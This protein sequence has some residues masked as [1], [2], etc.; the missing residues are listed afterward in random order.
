MT[1]KPPV[2]E[3]PPATR[4]APISRS[5]ASHDRTLVRVG[6]RTLELSNLEKVLYPGPEGGGFT[7]RQV[8]DYYQR[9]AKTIVPHLKDR[10]VT[11]KRYPNGVDHPFFYEKRCPSYKP[12]WLTTATLWSS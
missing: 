11:L 9:I 5:H 1:P 8:I 3:P 6:A 7:K 4:R 12:D 2:T 10:P